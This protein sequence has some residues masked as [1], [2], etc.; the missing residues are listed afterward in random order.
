MLA[1]IYV[2]KQIVL[3][4]AVRIGRVHD[5]KPTY[6]VFLDRYCP[7]FLHIVS[8]YHVSY[9]SLTVGCIF[10]S[11]A[12]GPDLLSRELELVR[13]IDLAVKE[14]RYDDA[15]MWRD[16]LMKLRNSQDDH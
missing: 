3:A 4:N 1:P 12:D 9:S 5:R 2:N 14:E 11:A 10:S 8:P 6:N 16:K 15:A 13:N 7:Q